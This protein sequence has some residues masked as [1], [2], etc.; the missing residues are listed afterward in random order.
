M[1]G[2]GGYTGCP[3]KDGYIYHG[4]CHK[5]NLMGRSPSSTAVKPLSRGEIGN[6][7]CDKIKWVIELDWHES[8]RSPEVRIDIREVVW[9]YRF[10][11]WALDR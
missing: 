11:E 6:S 4:E 8:A 3:S 5:G 1:R 9:A 7:V 2:N 10:Y